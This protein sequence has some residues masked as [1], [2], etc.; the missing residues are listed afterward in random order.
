MSGVVEKE[1]GVI[2]MTNHPFPVNHRGILEYRQ[3][4]ADKPR[5]AQ[6]ILS[7]SSKNNRKPLQIHFAT[8]KEESNHSR[9]MLRGF[10]FNDSVLLNILGRQKTRRQRNNL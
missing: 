7:N 5:P 9:K 6:A 4:Q 8:A 10:N 3:R 2:P 1:F